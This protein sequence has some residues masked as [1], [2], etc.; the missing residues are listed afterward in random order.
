M[1]T[2]LAFGPLRYALRGPLPRFL[3]PFAREPRG[4]ELPLALHV[5]DAP[6]GAVS[7]RGTAV[8]LE[9]ERRVIHLPEGSDPERAL[10]APLA[11]LAARDL[12]AAGALL[13]HASAVR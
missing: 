13:L 7:V 4:D 5:G 3:A 6:A 8:S 11:E 9:G 12:P 2:A 10:H 1:I